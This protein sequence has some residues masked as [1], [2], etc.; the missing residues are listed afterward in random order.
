MSAKTLYA[1]IT[2]DKTRQDVISVPEPAISSFS[3]LPKK[4]EL[5]GFG[6]RANYTDRATATSW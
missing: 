3:S 6:P 5:R 4:T 1:D 2:H